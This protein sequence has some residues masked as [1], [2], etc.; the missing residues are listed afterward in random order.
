MHGEL[1]SFKENQRKQPFPNGKSQQSNMNHGV[2]PGQSFFI[3]KQGF[4][5]M[6]A[7]SKFNIT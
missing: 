4:S 1:V 3:T 6:Q 5:T 2:K 7:L